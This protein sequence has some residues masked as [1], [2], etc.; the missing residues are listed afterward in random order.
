[1]MEA[2]FRET[3]RSARMISNIVL[4]PFINFFRRSAAPM[5]SS[6]RCLRTGSLSLSKSSRLCCR[7]SWYCH[8]S[9][10]GAPSVTDDEVGSPRTTECSRT[11]TLEKEHLLSVLLDA[12]LGSMEDLLTSALLLLLAIGG[13]RGAAVAAVDVSSRGNVVLSMT[14][15]WKVTLIYVLRLIM[16]GGAGRLVGWYTFL[17]QL[18]RLLCSNPSLGEMLNPARSLQSL[19][20][21]YVVL[22]FLMGNWAGRRLAYSSGRFHLVPC[23]FEGQIVGTRTHFAER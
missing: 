18:H 11:R 12:T 5:T 19:G 2:F 15:K 1:M 9:V 8:P 22:T 20:P 7:T 10:I 23:K 6:L 14:E 3:S 4:P 21:Q 17:L 16:A 13:E